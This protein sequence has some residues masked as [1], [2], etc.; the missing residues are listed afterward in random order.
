MSNVGYATLTILPS[1]RGFS[2]ALGREINP[3]LTA[4]GGTSGRS[5][6]KAFGGGFLPMMKN[7][8]GPAA[9]L[10]I[11]L[12]VGTGIKSGLQTAAFLEQAEISFE[13]LLGNKGAAKKMIAD[14]S[15]FAA[16][17]PF[18][19]PGLTA[20]VRSLLGAGAAAKT[21]LPTMTALGDT[22]G[23]L[24][25]NQEQLNSTVRAWTQ[26]MGKGKIS[27][28]EMLQITEAGIPI[29]SIASKAMGKPVGEIQKL[30]SEG[31]LLAKDV[32]PLIETQMKKD[33]GGSMA[34]QAKTLSGVWSTVKDTV[35]MAMAQALQPLVPILTTVLPP[36][37]NAM[38]TGIGWI[39]SA[40]EGLAKLLIG[41]DFTGALTRAFGWEEDSGIVDKILTI[42]T[43]VM[44][45]FGQIQSGTG[46]AGGAFKSITDALTPLWTII[47]T[48]VWPAIQ[49]LASAF[50]TGIQPV[51]AVL[52]DIITTS[53]IP[54]F[55]GMAA[56]AGPLFSQLGQTI[57]VVAQQIGPILQGIADVIRNVW[58]FI[59][60]F[61]MSTLQGI[62]GNVVGVFSGIFTVIQGVVNLVS[63]IF[64]G[65]WNAAWQALGQIVSGAVQAI[66]N[67]IQ[68]WIVGRVV[69]ILGKALGGIR[70]LFSGAW[71][72]ITGA[73][74]NAVTG[75][76]SIIGW[77]IAGMRGVI[78]GGLNAVRGLFTS[79]FNG[80][81]GFLRG[82]WSGIVNGVSGMIGNVVRF[83]GGLLGKIT[84]AIGNAGRALWDVGRNIIQGLIDGIGSMMGAIGRAIL[85]LVPGPIVGVFKNLLGIHSPSRVFRGFG[86]N[87][88][89]GLVLGIQD[90]HGGVKKAVEKLAG[91]PAGVSVKAPTVAAG[92]VTGALAT[93]AGSGLQP[94]IHQENHFNTPMSEE[95]YAELAARKLLRAGVGR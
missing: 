41:G 75:I 61:V 70:G 66:W 50:Q 49:N 84:G 38:A 30:A 2:S 90:M 31:K 37:A 76:S 55:Q 94:T 48:Q 4:A 74:R 40:V 16:S 47:T 77:L 35:N 14:V 71:N 9:G 44:D 28:E 52:G 56:Q 91:I 69:G 80:V 26:I 12:A 87:I 33:Y 23:A 63:A 65:D 1:A 15:K 93:V 10:G 13:T 6:G 83:F 89:E 46:P 59:G 60:P 18:E 34:K 3:A 51:L 67:F 39:S 36:A 8:I 78:S 25:L 79:I 81:L 95:A 92:G 7:M 43:A 86:V 45:F 68:I 58:G 42:R 24:G 85:S 57:N 72:F 29:W 17:T 21:V 82:V 32:L 11:G 53:I 19:I 88:G 27:A 62:F 5:A 22:A 54:A 73:V 64:R 20:N